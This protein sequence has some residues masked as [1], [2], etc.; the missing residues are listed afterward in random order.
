[1]CVSLLVLWLEEDHFP[2]SQGGKEGPV[3]RNV[4]EYSAPYC[5][6]NERLKQQL[7]SFRL[8]DNI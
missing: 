7:C 6:A 1:V 3:A 2:L 5:M 8:P 4:K